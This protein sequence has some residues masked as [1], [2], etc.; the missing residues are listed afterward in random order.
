MGNKAIRVVVALIAGVVLVLGRSIVIAWGPK[1]LGAILGRIA[2]LLAPE[3]IAYAALVGPL[4]G[5]ALVSATTYSL[6]LQRILLVSLSLFLTLV[7]AVRFPDSRFIWLA[8]VAVALAAIFQRFGRI[9]FLYPLLFTLWMYQS[10]EIGMPLFSATLLQRATITEVGIYVALLIWTISLTLL[11]KA[12]KGGRLSS[13]HLGWLLLFSFGG[14]LAFLLG[15]PPDRFAALAFLRQVCLASLALYILLTQLT[16]T[17]AEAERMM[18]ALLLGAMLLSF[19]VLVAIVSGQG[20]SDLVYKTGEISGTYR[21]W[22]GL[23]ITLGGTSC[24]FYLAELL[25][26]ALSLFLTGSRVWLRTLGLAAVAL[27]GA[28]I[29][30]MAS[31][32]AWVALAVTLPAIVLLALLMRR[33]WTWRAG[34]AVA[35]LVAMVIFLLPTMLS[36][37]GIERRIYGLSSMQALSS[38][39]DESRRDTWR[40]SWL[41]W[42]EHPMGMG[43]NPG[44]GHSLYLVL[45]SVMGPIALAG[46][47]GFMLAS[48]KDWLSRIKLGDPACTW[49]WVGALGTVAVSLIGGIAADHFAH[50]GFYMSLWAVCGI[51]TAAFQTTK[52]R[53]GV[54]AADPGLLAAPNRA[55]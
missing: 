29:L 55:I 44:W 49:M 28:V 46:Y 8:L 51:A 6:Q 18:V 16:R 26:L 41:L 36:A 12:H 9:A 22:F 21:L 47:L 14:F 2:T 23:T 4:I 40:A 15:E 3:P 17:P 1:L 42:Q 30:L 52:V 27:M 34:L 38:S 54:P 10:L 35:V 25:P 11:G 19:S 31:R 45:L 32:T 48:S 50:W 37:A 33:T 24:P 20:V 43:Y 39:L 7:I 53:Q 5:I 13:P